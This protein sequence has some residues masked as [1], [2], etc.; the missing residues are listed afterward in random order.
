VEANSTGGQG[1]RRAVT[2][3]DDVDECILLENTREAISIIHLCV[4]VS[5]Q[6]VGE[7]GWVLVREPGLMLARA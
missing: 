1:S 3:S 4:C 2:P 7:C 5:F 6:G